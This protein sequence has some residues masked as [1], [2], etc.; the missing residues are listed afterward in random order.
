MA[1]SYWLVTMGL[2][3]FFCVLISSFIKDEET[4]GWSQTII[5]TASE[6]GATR[7]KVLNPER[8]ED[9][10][11]SFHSLF[12]TICTFFSSISF[13]SNAALAPSTTITGLAFASLAVSTVCSKRLLPL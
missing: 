3:V 10:I 6:D 2:P 1:F 13:S 7:S 5:M 12:S 4:K 9:A 8:T 11:P